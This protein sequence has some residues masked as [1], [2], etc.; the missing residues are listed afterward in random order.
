MR[1]CLYVGKAAPADK[2]E[3]WLANAKSTCDVYAANLYREFTAKGHEVVFASSL[4]A[5]PH[6]CSEEESA[7]RIARYEKME[8]P[9]ADHA[10]CLQQ[11]GWKVREP[12]FFEKARAATKGLVCAI[13][14]HDNIIDGPQ[15]ILFTARRP[16]NSGRARYAGWAADLDMFTATWVLLVMLGAA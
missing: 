5:R 8:F 12:I 10:I 2:Q 6:D 15:D 16:V 7:K 3:E 11:N 14:D 9:E 1:I 4:A 13:C